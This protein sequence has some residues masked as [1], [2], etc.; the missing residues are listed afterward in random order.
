MAVAATPRHA[1]QV[2]SSLEPPSGRLAY[3]DNLKTV[4]IVTI[5]AAHT[6]FSYVATSWQFAGLSV[7]DVAQAAVSLVLTVGVAFAMGTFFYMAGLLAAKSL[8]H[9]GFRVFVRERLLRLGVPYLVLIPLIWPVVSYLLNRVGSTAT[10]ESL[11]SYWWRELVHLNSGALWF[12]LVLLLYSVA[13][14]I[15]RT[16]HPPTVTGGPLGPMYLVSLGVAIGLVTFAIRIALPMDSEQFLNVHLWQWPQCAFMFWFGT[17]CGERGWLK[18]LPDV[19]WHRAGLISLVAVLCV[20]LLL[21]AGGALSGQDVVFK[22]GWHWQAFAAAGIEGVLTVSAT[23]WL[24]DYFRRRHN[25]QGRF[26]RNLTR[27]AYA[28]YLVQ[29]GA[30]V[31]LGVVMRQLALPDMVKFLLVAPTAVVIS[32]AVAWLLVIQLK[33]ASRIL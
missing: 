26:A 5:I 11:W 19:W 27:S 3:L 33:F 6:A 10:S 31:A 1:P 4:L 2:D 20:P 17:V 32:F 15:W 12:I 30:L 23:L 25:R 7:S 8:A 9:H 13:Y 28:A 21:V 14:A 18:E 29:F 22:G 24:L 16:L